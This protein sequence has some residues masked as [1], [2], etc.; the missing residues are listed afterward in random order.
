MVGIF[1]DQHMRQQTGA[2]TPAFDRARWQS[3]LCEAL[4]T[5]TRK[6]RPHDAVHDEPTGHV[7]QFFGDVFTQAAQRPATLGAIVVAGGQLDFHA[8]DVIRDRAALGFI[9]W[10]F[11]WKTQLRRHL[12]NRDLAGFQGQLKLF[13]ALGRCA[14]PMVALGC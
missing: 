12:G 8:R 5:R 2:R 13:D 6:A 14:K 11:I 10:F 1:V 3:C 4:A 7:F 9:L